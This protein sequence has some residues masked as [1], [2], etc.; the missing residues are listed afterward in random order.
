MSSSPHRVDFSELTPTAVENG[1]ES[2]IWQPLARIIKV[3]PSEDEMVW[4]VQVA[5]LNAKTVLKYLSRP[6]Q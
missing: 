2:N 4:S 5:T 6:D 3:F 1:E